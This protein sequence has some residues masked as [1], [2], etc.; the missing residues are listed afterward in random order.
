MDR[1]P[2]SQKGGQKRCAA[3]GGVLAEIT[4]SDVLSNFGSWRGDVNKRLWLG[5]TDISEV[6]SL[7]SVQ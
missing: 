4:D 6:C 5:V 2:V 1:Y 3:V 7:R